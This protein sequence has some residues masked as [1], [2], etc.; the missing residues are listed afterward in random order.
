MK[1]ISVYPWCIPISIFQMKL[2]TTNK[3]NM[4]INR[5]SYD[6]LLCV[7]SISMIIKPFPVIES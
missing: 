3:L 4:N 2:F 7:L 6:S 1:I 5:T